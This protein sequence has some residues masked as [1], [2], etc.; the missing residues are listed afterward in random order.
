MQ[1]CGGE[2]DEQCKKILDV[3][4]ATE[5]SRLKSE[6]MIHKNLFVFRKGLPCQ[7]KTTCLSSRMKTTRL[8]D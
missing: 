8:A 4:Y 1:E 6:S 3:L 2:N 5:A 7:M